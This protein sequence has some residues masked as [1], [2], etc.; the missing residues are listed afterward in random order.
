VRA[1]V[2]GDG[3]VRLELV[4][5]ADEADLFMKALDDAREDL[6][7]QVPSRDATP[8]SP[9]VSGKRQVGVEAPR[10]AAADAL[11]HLATT[12]LARGNGRSDNTVSGSPRGE[13]VIHV[14]PE[15]ASGDGALEAALEDG[16]HVSAETL[17]RVACDGALVVVASDPAGN[18]LDVGRRSRAIP[19]AIRRALL[20][21]DH[22]CR[23]PGCVNR[24]F[25]HGH[26]IEHWIHGG[27]TALDN[28]LSLCSFHHRQVH[29]GGFRVSLTAGAEV[30]VWMP[31]GRRL[32][33]TPRLATDPGT[34]DWLAGEWDPRDGARPRMDGALPLP[35]W[36]GEPP[37]YEAAVDALIT[38]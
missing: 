8:L 5:S 2:L 20:L 31:D 23:F 22:H 16:T 11:V 3:L 10:A 38:A 36:D 15:L 18:V 25:L 35:I 37:D 34:L 24:A 13:V 29:E 7:P 19:T 33:A 28:L 27:R 4:L 6:S 14:G 1:R 32:P 17:R 30:E 21:R 12:F 9:A 26:H